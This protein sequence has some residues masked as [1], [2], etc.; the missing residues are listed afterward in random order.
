MRKVNVELADRS[1]EILIGSGLLDSTATLLDMRGSSKKTVIIS[2]TTVS[3][4]YGKN[5][6]EALSGKGYDAAILTVPDGEAYKSL[7]TA[8]RLYT[9][10][11]ECFAER[12]TPVLALG[13]GVIGDLAGFV[14]ATY[15]RGIPLVQIPTTLLAQVDSSIGGKVAVDHEK[16]KNKIGTFYQP[17]IVIS[18][19]STLKTLPKK[20]FAN[21]MAEVIKSAVIRDSAF[22]VF[23]KQ[24]LEAIIKQD[25]DVIEEMVFRAASIKASIVTRDEMDTGIRNILNFGHTIGH[26][27]ES[28]SNLK[29]AH[30]QAIAIGMIA[31]AKIARSMGIFEKYE[32]EALE[33]LLSDAGLSTEIPAMN[34]DK[35]LQAIKHD[36]KTV[37]GKIRFILPRN[38]GDVYIT[39]QVDISTVR[40]VF[41]R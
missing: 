11:T 31:E 18:D 22:F 25:N 35:I 27:I 38:I 29:I 15:M 37:D 6:K 24:N 41:N 13:G 30:G 23:I 40:E 19:I 1:Y 4:L 39:D 17:S 20:E 2:N 14:A 36:K 5:L 16:L 12:S 32:L 3:K 26:A 9:G 33:N 7:D 34:T 21:G 10:L 8:G 28:V